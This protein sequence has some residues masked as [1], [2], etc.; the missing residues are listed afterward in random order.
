MGHEVEPIDIPQALEHLIEDL[1]GERSLLLSVEEI[2]R[3]RETEAS[4]R[5]VLRRRRH[6]EA[7]SSGEVRERRR[8]HRQTHARKEPARGT[9]ASVHRSNRKT[10]L[11]L[12][13]STP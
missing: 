3:E 8:R 2:Q 12:T 9:R 11:P 7:R 6:H 1:T 13:A 5:L 10:T 4:R